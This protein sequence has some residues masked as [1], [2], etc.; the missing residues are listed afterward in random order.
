MLISYQ[1]LSTASQHT[2]DKISIPYNVTWQDWAMLTS[3][4]PFPTVSLP[5]QCSRDILDMFQNMPSLLLVRAPAFVSF[6][7][8]Q[9]GL[10][11][12]QSSHIQLL[13]APQPLPQRFLTTL[14]RV[15]H[16]QSLSCYPV[17]IS[18]ITYHYL[19]LSC[20]QS[21]FLVYSLVSLS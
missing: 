11:C 4:F 15:P 8:S 20:S 19:Q 14:S 16:P 1:A 6:F 5:P 9:P 18:S 17:L 2:Q 7:F 3:Q 10:F 12:E 21:V 13:L